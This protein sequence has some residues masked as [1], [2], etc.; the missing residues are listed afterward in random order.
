MGLRHWGPF[1]YDFFFSKLNT[2]VLHNLQLVEFLD[3]TLW[4]QRNREY[5]GLT[6]SGI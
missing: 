2:T 6:I 5:E 3:V 4:M 1:I